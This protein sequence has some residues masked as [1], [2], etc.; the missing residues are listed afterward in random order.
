MNRSFGLRLEPLE[1]RDNPSAVT[2]PD[3]GVGSTTSATVQAAIAA[4]T[5]GVALAFLIAPGLTNQQAAAPSDAGAGNTTSATV[6]AAI[7][8]DTTGVALAVLIAPDLG[9]H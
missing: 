5:T 8:A 3:L 2:T 4:E 1:Q 9:S 6:Q 7:A